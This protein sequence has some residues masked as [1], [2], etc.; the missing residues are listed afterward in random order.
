MEAGNG[1]GCSGRFSAGRLTT[2]SS[3]ANNCNRLGDDLTRA[4][5]VH[6]EKTGCN[7]RYTDYS[8]FMG[9]AANN[10]GGTYLSS[11][12]TLPLWEETPEVGLACGN[13]NHARHPASLDLYVRSGK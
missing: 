3:A 7:Y 10:E 4:D 13:H 5:L 12:G 2:L 8:S 9:S 1:T 11:N 6:N